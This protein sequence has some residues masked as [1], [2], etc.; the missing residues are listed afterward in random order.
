MDISKR[1][2]NEE[3]KKGIPKVI[4][5]LLEKRRRM[6]R[7]RSNNVEFA[8]LSK[9]IRKMLQEWS[10]SK[11][12][13][14]LNEAIIEGRSI[15]KCM[16]NMSIGRKLMTGIKDKHG[17][18]ITERNE[19]PRIIA[20]F[21]QQLY[22]DPKRE[23]QLKEEEQLNENSGDEEQDIIERI[24]ILESEVRY[25]IDKLKD[26]KA[27]GIDGIIN[28]EIKAG[29]TTMVKELRKIF[30]TCLN[31]K[32]VPKIWLKAI[33]ILLYKKGDKHDLK[34]YRPLSMLCV[35]YKLFMSIITRRIDD[36]L[37][38][39]QT[40]E[41]TGFR[42]NYSTCDNI[43]TIKQLIHQAEAYNFEVLILFLDFE[44]AFDSIFTTAIMKALRKAGVGKRYRDII[45][46]IYEGSEMIIR[47]EGEECTIKLEKGLK[48]GDIA[49]AKIFNSV[50]QMVFR[51]LEW[52][53][54]GI[55][56]NGEHLSQLRFADDVVIIGK[57]CGELKTMLH[58][59][60]EETNKVGLKLNAKKCKLMR[61]NSAEETELTIENESIENVED[62]IYLGHKLSIYGQNKEITRR[63]SLAWNTFNKYGY[64]FRSAVNMEEKK[65]LWNMCVLPSLIYASE[66]WIMDAKTIKRLR[67]T[68]G[69]IQPCKPGYD[70]V[71]LDTTLPTWIRPC[72]PG[73]DPVNLDTTLRTW[74]RPCKPGYDPANLDTTLQTWIPPC[75]PGY[76]PANLDTTLQTWIPPCKPGYDP[77]NL[78]TTLQ[79]WIRPCKPGYDP[80][81]LDTTLQ[82]WIRPCKPGYDPANLDTTL[83]TWIRPCKPGYHPANLDT[84]LQTWIRPCKPGYD[85]ANL[86]TTLQ[87][88]IRP[89]KPGYDPANLDTTLQTWIRPCKPGYDPQTWIRPCKPGYDP[90]NLDTTLQTWIRPCKPGY[91]PANLDTTL[92]TWIRPCK[93]GYDPANLDT[94]LQTWIRPCKPGYDPANLD[95]TLQTWIRPCK[96]GYDPANLDTTLQTWIRPCKPG[97]DPAN[98][99]TTLQTWIR[100][101]KPGYD[102]ANL[103]TTL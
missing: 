32:V 101:C 57:N 31:L 82:T 46:H 1:S 78:D 36:Q 38:L 96:P 76:D 24:E 43:L 95:T 63:I 81:N 41:Q 10:D 27:G 28:E 92:Q 68:S 8:E 39:E 11:R 16:Q 102:P 26:R 84:T 53:K 4:R 47:M 14:E 73:Y 6:K 17:T 3:E 67:V 88:W 34:N 40:I 83:Q 89:C 52:S 35:M 12:I 85:P 44:K 13:Q 15:K 29:G 22:S 45:E 62:F 87:T 79:T 20:E 97:Y 69:S 77:A 86:D 21:Y 54:F 70:P 93:P 72:K 48:Q 30:N 66:T 18:L 2:T 100:P 49:S 19:I 64:L 60:I 51:N 42:R 99:D 23:D 50:I 25:A 103:D 80:V 75:K 58:S 98:L 65:K 9:T 74:I 94:T 56:I 71:N 59:L 5:R 37:E 61:I 7:T 33:L 91:D 90:A 55:N